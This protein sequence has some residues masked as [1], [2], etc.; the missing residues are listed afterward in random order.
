M[1]A[2]FCGN[3]ASIASRHSTAT[4]AGAVVVIE[5]NVV[6]VVVEFFGGQSSL[7]VSRGVTTAIIARAGNAAT[8]NVRL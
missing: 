2:S 8:I 5:A 6:A 4:G 3:H 7:F 1:Y